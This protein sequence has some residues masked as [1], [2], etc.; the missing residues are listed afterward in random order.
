MIEKKNDRKK[1]KILLIE[2]K[3]KYIKKDLLSSKGNL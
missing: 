2:I 3:W 1:E